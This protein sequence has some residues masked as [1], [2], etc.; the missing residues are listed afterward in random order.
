LCYIGIPELHQNILT[1]ET[2][3]PYSPYIFTP[4]H[5]NTRLSTH[6]MEGRGKNI[7]PTFSAAMYCTVQCAFFNIEEK[8]ENN[9]VMSA[10]QKILL[11]QDENDR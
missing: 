7:L 11:K 9:F 4:S 8:N 10:S 6:L 3:A 1:F 2:A 5:G